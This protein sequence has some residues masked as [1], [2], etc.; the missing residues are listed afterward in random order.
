MVRISGEGGIDHMSKFF[1]ATVTALAS[2]MAMGTANS[3]YKF[4]P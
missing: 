3:A 2:S 1:F 4:G